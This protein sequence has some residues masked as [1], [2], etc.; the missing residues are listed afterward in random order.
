MK[1]KARCQGCHWYGYLDRHHVIPI[2]DGGSLNNGKLD[3]C[4]RCHER[5]HRLLA[6][7]KQRDKDG[8]LAHLGSWN[9][10]ATQLQWLREDRKGVLSRKQAE[11]LQEKFSDTQ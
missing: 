5:L 11:M 3:L 9:V 6:E 4:K 7:F 1:P 10:V 8:Y 2:K